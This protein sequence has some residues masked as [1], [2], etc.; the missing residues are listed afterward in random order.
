MSTVRRRALLRTMSAAAAVIVVALVTGC[1]PEPTPAATPS[2]EPTPTRTAVPSPSPSPVETSSPG[3]GFVLPDRCEDIYSAEMLAGLNAQN[4]P[5]NDPGVT[6]NSTQTVEALELL[7]SGI[8]T[9]RCS[10]GQPSE[11]GL[12]TNV[13]VADAADTAALLD[14]LRATGFGCESVW[15]GTLCQIEQRTI[16]LDDNEV[17]LG[18]SHFVRGHG[19]VSTRWINFAPDGYTEDIVATLWD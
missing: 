10:W 13:S 6:M 14:A 17:I 12:A 2:D 7:T 5:L 8:P 9:I 11:Y 15:D 19:W 4:P 3:A 1:Q 18:E 16:D